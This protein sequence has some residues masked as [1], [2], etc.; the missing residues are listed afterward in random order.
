MPKVSV[1]IPVYGVEKYIERCARSLFEQT[2]DDIEYLFINDCTPDKSMEILKDILKDYPHRNSQVLFH[3]MKKNSGQAAVRKWGI[4]HA[5]GEYLIHCDSDDWVDVDMY[6]SMYE[7]A[8][9][10]D[11]DVVICDY[12]MSNG[13]EYGKDYKGCIIEDKNIFIEQLLNRKV[14]WSLWNKLFKRGVCYDNIVYP[15]CNMAEDY[16]L[17]AQ[18]LLLVQKIAY[19]PI[20]YYYYYVNIG[21]ITRP[22]RITAEKAMADYM[23]VKSNANIVINVLKNSTTNLLKNC[24]VSI[25]YTVVANL[26]PLSHKKEFRKIIFNTYRGLFKRVLLSRKIPIEC[27]LRMILVK[28]YLFPSTF[29]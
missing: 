28:L 16:A 29:R 24:T 20:P 21:S 15:T 17:C 4:Q 2:L 27:K 14:T 6:R 19:I 22:Q 25:E 10:E 11:A 8:I 9:E 5:T 13:L 7:K 18:S 26:F 1:I 3:S 12:V 23:A